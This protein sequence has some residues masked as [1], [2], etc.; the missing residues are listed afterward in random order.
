MKLPLACEAEYHESFVS[1]EE[2]QVIFD[3][4]CDS[5]DMSDPGQVLMADGSTREMRPW[6][7][8][9]VDPLLVDPKLFPDYH[10]RR[11]EW[12]SVLVNLRNSIERYTGQKFEVCVCLYYPDGQ[13][14]M[15]FHYDPPA[16][17]RTNLLPSINLGASREFQLRRKS[18]HSELHSIEL[19][20]GSL[21]IMGE[22]CQEEYEHAVPPMPQCTGA[23][24]NLTF[25]P[26]DW[27][28]GTKR[29]RGE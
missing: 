6:K 24:I 23:R 16:F 4:I 12:P 15:G 14:S 3:W 18:N 13:E 29:G 21:I 19:Q 9:F 8:M 17:G 25:R 1:K 7:M 20:D 27:P 26:F 5:H 10:G 2:S 22:G 28:V 11:R